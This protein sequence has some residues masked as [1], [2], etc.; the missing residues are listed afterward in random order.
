L[1]FSLEKVSGGR[2]ME[3][4]RYIVE[5]L[6]ELDTEVAI[7]GTAKQ[8]EVAGGWC[9]AVAAGIAVYLATS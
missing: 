2:Q 5:D 1:A 6:P 4:I 3:E 7:C 8:Q 9:L